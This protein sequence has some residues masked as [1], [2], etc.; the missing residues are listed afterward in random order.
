MALTVS[1]A[2]LSVVLLVGAGLFLRSLDNALGLD[3]GI[4]ANRVLAVQ[5]RWPAVAPFP[6]GED[7]LARMRRETRSAY[8]ERAVE[9]LRTLPYVA[10]AAVAVGTPFHSSF[11]VDLRVPGRDSIP[12]L[13]GGGPYVSAVTPGYFQTAGTRVLRGR[14]F[15]EGEGA[16]SEAVVIVN[17]TM[18]RTLWPGEDA[19]RFAL[20]EEP[21]MQYYIPFGQEVGIGGSVLLIRPRGDLHAHTEDLRE[22]LQH[23]DPEGGFVHIESLQNA[24][25]PQIRPWRLG[26][27]LFGIFGALALLIAGV[28]LYSVIAYSVSQRTHELGVRMALGARRPDVRRLILRQGMLVTLL[29][30]G[31][32]LLLSL[33]A[34]P[35][36]GSLLFEASPRDPLVFAVV[37]VAIILAALLA[38]IVPATRAMRVDPMTALRTE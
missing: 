13:P 19:R 25:D 6:S 18:E 11:G 9:H 29:G 35:L 20:R 30:A 5:V 24:L 37:L 28:G 14:D 15:Q 21:A 34:G 8:F 23:L 33:G 1:Q 32:G 26:A 4:D 22:E 17:E 12:E 27:V 16:G 38:S 3:L 2:S 7:R 31:I 10:H 36:V